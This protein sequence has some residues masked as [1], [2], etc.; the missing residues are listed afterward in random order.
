MSPSTKKVRI[1]E[2]SFGAY[3]RAA[4]ERSSL[5]LSQAADLIKVSKAHVW[6]MERGEAR[7]PSI[8]TLANMASAYDLDLGDLAHMAAA[9]APGTDYRAAVKELREAKGRLVELGRRAS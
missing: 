9:A 6:S 8:V 4:R 2:N 5:S 3:I 1:S 7:N